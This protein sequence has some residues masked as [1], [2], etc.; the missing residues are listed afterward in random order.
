MTIS[1]LDW[2]RLVRID[3]RRKLRSPIT[4]TYCRP[5]ELPLCTTKLFLHHSFHHFAQRKADLKLLNEIGAALGV[6]D[7]WIVL[8]HGL[9]LR[10]RSSV[11][12]PGKDGRCQVYECFVAEPD[13][14]R[15]LPEDFLCRRDVRA[16]EDEATGGELVEERPRVR[17]R[18]H[19]HRR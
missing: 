7:R 1:R 5:S 14:E 19:R 4:V 17:D 8:H 18:R 10:L 9:V 3:R 12:R 2:H 13:E 15:P 11:L 6:Y 16:E